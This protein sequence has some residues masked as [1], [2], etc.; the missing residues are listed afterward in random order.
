M[1]LTISA[2]A[3]DHTVG[4]ANAPVTLVEYGNYECSHC[5][6]AAQI[7]R[8]LQAEFDGKIRR[9][10]RHFP[11]RT[12]HSLSVRAAEAAEAAAIQ[13]KFW[14]MHDALLEW[15]D[16]LSEASLLFCAT[17]IGLNLPQFLHDMETKVHRA[18]VEQD[19][20]SGVQSGVASTPTFFINGRRHEDLAD[21][22]LLRAAILRTAVTQTAGAESGRYANV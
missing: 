8:S 2:S 21:E 17:S 15:R 6:S 18:R 22:E 20:K 5:R 9:V 13:G 7:V 1:Q 19:F 14:Q 4:L 3:R 16:P 12:M 10:Y 11:R